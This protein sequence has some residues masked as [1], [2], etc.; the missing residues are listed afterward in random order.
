[1]Y[2]FFSPDN[3]RNFYLDPDFIQDIPSFNSYLNDYATPSIQ[4]PVTVTEPVYTLN[5]FY[6]AGDPVYIVYP[7][8]ARGE[9]VLPQSLVTSECSDTNPL[10]KY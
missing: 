2:V 3:E 10:R 1:M 9:F 4:Q 8:E 7:N 6:K 5:S